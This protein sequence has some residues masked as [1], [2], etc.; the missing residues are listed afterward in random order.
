[1]S[2]AGSF[3]VS[4][5]P[6]GLVVETIT[7]NTGGPVGPDGLDNINIVGDGLT[8]TVTG[9]PG[10]NTL[11]IFALNATEAQEFDADIGSA[12]PLAGVINIITNNAARQAGSS[13]LFSASGNTVLFSVTDANDNTIIGKG[14]GSAALIGDRNVALGTLSVPVATN[15]N[16]NIMI[17]YKTGNSI[18]DASG[19]IL[20]GSNAGVSVTDGQNNVAIG[21]DAGFSIIGATNNV[22]IGNIAGRSLTSGGQNVLIGSSAGTLL[23][24]GGSNVAIG[25][26]AASSLDSGNANIIIGSSAG[27]SLFTAS[28]NILIGA[29]AGASS[30][31]DSGNIMIGV[32]AGSSINN[33]TG[34]VLMGGGAGTSLQ[35]VTHNTFYGLNAGNSILTGNN[36]VIIGA[37]A[38]TGYG[39]NESSNIV[40]NDNG[41]APAGQ[42]HTLTIGA[43]TGTGNYELNQ[44]FISGIYGIAP[45]AAIPVFINSSGQ[46]GTVG[47]GGG[48]LVATLTANSG[49]PVSPAAGN[50][51][52][53]GDTTTIEIVG[54]PGTNTLTASTT[55]A[56]PVLF[57]TDSGNATPSAGILN[58]VGGKGIVV[59]GASNTITVA[60]TGIFF[61][62]IN[63]NMSP[64]TVLTDDVY[65]S[66]DSTG[67][68]IT[69]LLPDAAFLGEPYIIKD[70]TGTAAVNNITVTTISGTD[71]IDG[72][73]SFI[74]DSA[75]QS[76]SLVGNGTS[77]EI[78]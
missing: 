69:I 28:N 5:L 75:Y 7:G 67:G 3:A 46:L 29:N 24:T 72:V 55:G 49:G 78:Y 52:V 30:V 50:I 77:Y 40:I 45:A 4:S 56:V 23:D 61:T 25:P 70:R 62:Y 59:S 6:P 64:Y 47:S 66:V 60:S 18:T 17:G 44:A 21:N 31:N 38:A 36:N 43:G 19:N 51:N 54:N 57:V 8:V 73:T 33:G 12:I 11:T 22:V 42:S 63:V 27:A 32:N 58:I 41:T 74:M 9:N 65:L 76:I 35:S 16:N 26:N 2:Q 37:N 13:V 68:P 53:V 20:I 14:S 34:N 48:S 39:S 1:M 10:T 71:T 15:A